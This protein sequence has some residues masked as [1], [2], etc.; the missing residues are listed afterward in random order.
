M[1]KLILTFVL[2]TLSL[3]AF[4]QEAFYIY[5]N[6]GDFNGFFY[7]EVIEM[8]QS[9]ISVDSIEYDQW[10]TQEVVLEDTI[11]RI[12]LAAIDSIGFQQP[13]IKLNPR[14]KFIEQEGM[15]PYMRGVSVTSMSLENLP[16]D[17]IPQIGD[18]W[19][20][21]KTDACAE[22]YEPHLRGSFSLVVESVSTV[23]G[24]TNVR[25]HE[26]DQISDVFEQ[27]I[28][29]E[30]LGVDQNNQVHRRIAGCTPDGLPRRSKQGEG[31]GEATLIDFSH[32]LAYKWDITENTSVSFSADMNLKM[33]V[34]AAYNITWKRILVTIKPDLS[35]NIQPSLG[36]SVKASF[37][38]KLSDVIPLPDGIPFPAAAPIFELC[39]LP[40]LFMKA[41]GTFEASLSLPQVGLGVGMDVIIDS[42]NIPFVVA[43]TVHLNEDN[44]GGPKLNLLDMTGEVSMKG[45]IYTGVEFQM[46]INTNRW[47]EKILQAGIGLHFTAGPKVETEF[48]YSTRLFDINPLLDYYALSHNAWLKHTWLSLGANAGAKAQVGWSDPDEVTFLEESADFYITDFRL[49]HQ[50]NEPEAEVAGDYVV[51]NLNPEPGIALLYHDFS[52]GIFD[53]YDTALIPRPYYVAARWDQSLI[54]EDEEFSAVVPLSKFKAQNYEVKTVVE[55]PD[56]PT[57]VVGGGHFSVPAKIEAD[58][59]SVHFNVAGSNEEIIPFTSN[60]DRVSVA[61]GTIDTLNRAEGR[62]QARMK[63]SPNRRIFTT[64]NISRDDPRAPTISAAADHPALYASCPIEVK[65]DDN[66][67]SNVSVSAYVTFG[68]AQSDPKSD[69]SAVAQYT[70]K[71]TCSRIT[72]G[73]LEMTGTQ[74]DEWGYTNS[75][76]FIVTK[77]VIESTDDNE[78]LIYDG[79]ITSKHVVDGITESDVSI[80]FE[81]F[82]FNEIIHNSDGSWAYI[83]QYQITSGSATY[84]HRE[85]D[86][87][88]TTEHYSLK[89]GSNQNSCSI[90]SY[91]KVPG[92]E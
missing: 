47:F 66:D 27:Y 45:T 40:T 81:N 34:R 76:R 90:S 88:I 89:Q 74:T 57:P 13:E 43:G 65:Q 32:T 86:E 46:A 20:G 85:I 61:G 7:D 8:R 26:V 10:V 83:P 82:G 49:A 51:V 31:H 9:K 30:E 5:R 37:E 12:P 73:M 50:F 23:N 58:K 39:P 38:K 2:G 75:I 19:I 77:N 70:G 3:C 92:E 36:L 15:S 28:T 35:L 53:P 84:R 60:S 6:D 14:V 25:G 63:W 44:P 52:A 17:K 21:L 71:V 24:W 48:T 79:T 87:S 78:V 91:V 55:G 22:L 69:G 18:V 56:G 41:E 16:A 64:G 80:S 68:Y 29:V 62:Y 59:T 1:R 72:E 4:S 42:W 11:Y 54:N 33:C 67:L